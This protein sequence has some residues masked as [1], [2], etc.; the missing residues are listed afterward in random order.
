MYSLF[1]VKLSYCLQSSL[2]N[3]VTRFIT[4][5]YLVQKLIGTLQDT[6]GKKMHYNIVLKISKTNC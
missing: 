2:N 3:L 4:Y 1:N 6:V 5:A